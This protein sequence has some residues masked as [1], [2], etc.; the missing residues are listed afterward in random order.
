MSETHGHDTLFGKTCPTISQLGHVGISICGKVK[1]V[2]NHQPVMVIVQLCHD[3]HG[4]D[5]GG[6]DGGED[7]AYP[8]LRINQ[9][10]SPHRAIA[11]ITT[12]NHFFH[13][14]LS[15]TTTKRTTYTNEVN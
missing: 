7:R 4:C 13:W 5:G 1:H 15:Q 3:D 8:H 2:P 10:A 6:D 9:V 11:A 12:L 14:W